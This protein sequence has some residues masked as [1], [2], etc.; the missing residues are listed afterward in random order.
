[1]DSSGKLSR[2]WVRWSSW[3]PWIMHFTL[4]FN[5]ARILSWTARPHRWLQVLLATN[6]PN[7]GLLHPH[8]GPRC[9]G[10]VHGAYAGE[11][12]AIA[13]R[14]KLLVA[15]RHRFRP[16][17]ITDQVHQAAGM[18]KTD[19]RF[20]VSTQC[21]TRRDVMKLMD[22]KPNFRHVGDLPERQAPMQHRQHLAVHTDIEWHLTNC[23]GNP[24]YQPIA[25]IS[26]LRRQ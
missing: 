23:K 26:F 12:S 16:G 5:I 7:A 20:F 3:Y 2:Q 24:T 13:S 22:S 10:Q 21:P 18:G 9:V 17:C 4:H 14:H 19:L 8:P 1:M 25:I 15:R 11:T 6:C